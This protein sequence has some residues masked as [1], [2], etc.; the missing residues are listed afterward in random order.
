MADVEMTY[1]DLIDY[2]ADLNSDDDSDYIMVDNDSDTISISS[3]DNV[4]IVSA[5]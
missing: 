3:S 5:S 1:K 4:A 2:Y